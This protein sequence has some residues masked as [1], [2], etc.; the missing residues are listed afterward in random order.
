MVKEA[1]NKV[2][3]KSSTMDVLIIICRIRFAKLTKSKKKMHF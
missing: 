2:F 3:L 1:K